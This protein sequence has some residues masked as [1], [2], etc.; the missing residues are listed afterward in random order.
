MNGHIFWLNWFA[1]END[2]IYHIFIVKMDHL[3]LVYTLNRCS[4]NLLF[5]F[6]VVN[7]H[8]FKQNPNLFISWALDTNDE[9]DYV[10]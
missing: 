6:D 5:H 9:L 10:I 1:F 2:I 8:Q 7:M 3:L 4:I